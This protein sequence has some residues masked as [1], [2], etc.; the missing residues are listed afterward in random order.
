MGSWARGKRPGLEG[1]WRTARVA[2][3]LRRGKLCLPVPTAGRPGLRRWDRETEP[4][5]QRGEAG[6]REPISHLSNGLGGPGLNLRQTAFALCIRP[7]GTCQHS[8]GTEI[9]LFIVRV[10][11]LRPRDAELACPRTC[12]QGVAEQ[13]LLV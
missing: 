11:L 7:L 6:T 10:E 2:P 5:L 12:S 8:C 4:G 3:S 9:I 13:G 1:S